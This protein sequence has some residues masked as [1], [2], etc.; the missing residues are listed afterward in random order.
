MKRL[1]NAVAN[2]PDISI[3]LMFD[4][5]V[6]RLFCAIVPFSK[7]VRQRPL[8]SE[9]AGRR[10]SD[11][12][13]DNI[14]S[15]YKLL[16]RDGSELFEVK[17]VSELLADNAQLLSSLKSRTMMDEHL[18]SRYVQSA[19]NTLARTVFNAPASHVLHD[20]DCGGLLT[21]SLLT[22]LLSLDCA[23]KLECYEDIC[24]DDYERM[25]VFF[26]DRKSVV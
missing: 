13:E 26:I 23:R 16:L 3:V 8:L 20:S 10:S 25:E 22:A 7:E 17:G 15:D 18:Y 9:P 14:Y 21:H 2:P 6:K 19:I 5:F 11:N 1:K 24:V 12:A 4:K